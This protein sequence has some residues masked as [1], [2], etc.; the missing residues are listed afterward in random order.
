MADA[1]GM[2]SAG[3]IFIMWAVMMPA[4]IPG[5]LP[6]VA[7]R[8][9]LAFLGYLLVWIAFSAAA[10]SAHLGLVSLGV[11]SAEMTLRSALLAA[12]VVAAVGVYQ[13][14][15]LKR[16]FLSRCRA[17]C[18]AWAN[19]PRGR[20]WPAVADGTRYALS[21]AGCCWALMALLFVAGVMNVFAMAAI[22]VFVL[23]E[24]V[25]PRGIA[26]SKIAGAALLACGVVMALGIPRTGLL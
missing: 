2:M 20:G 9:A 21:C 18:T 16:A 1:P 12:L 3:A 5:A 13:L 22:A 11:L 24:K 10:A 17:Q 7:A 14:S 19:A 4:M 26:F 15:P 8:G 6:L 23:A 25:V